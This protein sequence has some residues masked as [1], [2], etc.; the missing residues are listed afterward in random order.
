MVIREATEADWVSIWP[1]FN[2]IV[3]AGDTYAYAIDTTEAQAKSI[4]LNA[5]RK[6]Y[7]CL[8]DGIITGTYYIKTNQAGPGKHVCNCGYMVS[9]QARGKGLAS[10]MCE[11]SQQV[12]LSLGYKAMQFNFVASSN[13]GAVRLWKKLGFEQ[14]GCLPDAFNHP[15]QG[16]VDALVMYKQL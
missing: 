11:H 15:S 9:P 3:A 14:V 12:A 16:Y 4:W 2:V 8:L 1:I 13:A 10:A 6:T 7:V 5:P